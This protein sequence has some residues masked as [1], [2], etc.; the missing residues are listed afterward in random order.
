MTFTEATLVNH[1]A[2][3]CWNAVQ[4]KNGYNNQ[5]SKKHL[6]YC[7]FQKE[8]KKKGE[9]DARDAQAKSTASLA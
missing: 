4:G 2:E 8:L 1:E 7:Y 3:P 5:N 9:S 6:S